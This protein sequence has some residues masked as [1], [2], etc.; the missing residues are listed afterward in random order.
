MKF[1]IC[2]GDS[3]TWGQGPAGLLAHFADPDVQPGELRP[4]PFGFPFYVNLLRDEVNRRTGSRAVEE[5]PRTVIHGDYRTGQVCGAARFVFRFEGHNNYKVASVIDG[6]SRSSLIDART[7]ENGE[8]II[9]VPEPMHLYRAE[10]YSGDYAV[11]NAGVGSCTTRRYLEQFYDS[12]VKLFD[13]YC[14]VAEAHSINDWLNHIPLDEVKTNLGKILTGCPGAHPVLVTVQPIAGETA[15]PFSEIDYE[16]YIRVSRETAEENGF[17]LVDANR[18]IG[19]AHFSDNW[20]PDE[21]GHAIY[22]G[23]IVKA[24]EDGG[25]L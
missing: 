21:E 22:A 8:L 15:Q 16:N 6:V 5:E 7:D 12:Y 11:I 9:T 18:A 13:P 3:H 2:T 19:H 10:Y 25:I 20:H 14:I 23:E 17:T 4:S 1:I 24:L